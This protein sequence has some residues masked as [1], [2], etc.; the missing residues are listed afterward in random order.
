M[1]VDLGEIELAGEKEDDGA[2]GGEIAQ[3]LFSRRYAR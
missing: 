2:N 1:W 3:R